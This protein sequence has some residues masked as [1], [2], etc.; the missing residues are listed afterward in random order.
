LCSIT[1]EDL[2]EKWRPN[3]NLWEDAMR[4]D[5]WTVVHHLRGD[6]HGIP[7]E[8]GGI[9]EVKPE[10]PSEFKT[11][12]TAQWNAY[13]GAALIL[14]DSQYL[15]IR[16]RA[17]LDEKSGMGMDPQLCKTLKPLVKDYVIPVPG[18]QT[19]QND[20]HEQHKGG[21]PGSRGRKLSNGKHPAV[22]RASSKMR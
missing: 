15:D 9:P 17:G 20:H 4:R 7:L 10:V 2:D 11:K 8:L 18:E 21:R 12:L 3:S 1:G 22:K 6:G 13:A 5:N 14:T 19:L 16:R